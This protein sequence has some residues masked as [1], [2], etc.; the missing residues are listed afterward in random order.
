MNDGFEDIFDPLPL[1][2]R[3]QDRIVRVEPN[4]SDP[5]GLWPYR[6][7]VEFT[8]P[9]PDLELALRGQSSHLEGL[10]DDGEQTD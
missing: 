10:T 9:Q 7:A 8:E 2:G 4:T 3:T 5:N 1:L 6:I